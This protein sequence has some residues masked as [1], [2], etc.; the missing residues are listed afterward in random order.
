MGNC[1]NNLVASVQTRTLVELDQS[2]PR[3]WAPARD[4]QILEA[5]ALREIASE[6][7]AS[8]ESP[9]AG[10]H[11]GG[12]GKAS[13]GAEP[14]ITEATLQAMMAEMEVAAQESRRSSGSTQARQ[15]SGDALGGCSALQKRVGEAKSRGVKG[16]D[17]VSPVSAKRK[18]DNMVLPVEMHP[19]L[20]ALSSAGS[21]TWVTK[22]NLFTGMCCNI[23]DA[24]SRII[25]STAPRERLAATSQLE[26]LIRE[27]FRLHDLNSNGVL[28]EAELI[29]IN[30]MICEIHYGSG[31][32][33]GAAI[34]AKYR[35]L[36]REY[37]DPEGKPVPY[38]R[39]RDYILHLVR[40][41]D[42]YEEAQAMIIEQWI[43][44]AQT[45]RLLG[46]GD[47]L[48]SLGVTHAQQKAVVPAERER[49]N[50]AWPFSQCTGGRPISFSVVSA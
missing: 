8:S 6:A 22:V 44:E 46:C 1:H 28:E 23:E 47:P 4:L 37:L 29:T 49:S 36:F 32:K 20:V 24:A 18:G 33:S 9:K 42:K 40:Q 48:H 30:K 38:E 10:L 19:G 13:R 35:A 39:F 25:N 45:A 31:D 7:R 14:A 15:K 11:R 5:Q 34:E 21:P 27:L 16:D 2:S 17:E 43:A 3:R 50:L 12:A 26:G 41:Y